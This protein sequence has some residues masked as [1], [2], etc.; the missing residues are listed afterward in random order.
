MLLVFFLP[1]SQWPR[2]SA[3]EITYGLYDWCA[4]DQ[5][6]HPYRWSNQ[7]CSGTARCETGDNWGGRY[8]QPDG[9]CFIP[10]P[11]PARYPYAIDRY[12]ICGGDGA[13]QQGKLT[14]LKTGTV[15]GNWW[16]FRDYDNSLYV[17][18]TLEGTSDA[19]A[20]WEFGTQN[21]APVNVSILPSISYQLPWPPA[22]QSAIPNNGRTGL[23]TC[24][25]YKINLRRVCDPTWT[26]YNPLR[27]DLAGNGFCQAL[28]SDAP[29]LTWDFSTTPFWLKITPFAN[30]Y[31]NLNLMGCGF[32]A[33]TVELN[34]GRPLTFWESPSMCSPWNQPAAPPP[35]NPPPSPETP[36]AP[37]SPPPLPPQPQ[38]PPPPP[39]VAPY[40]TRISVSSQG[41][42]MVGEDCGKLKGI[43]E[44][45]YLSTAL[46][47]NR[48]AGA[49][50]IGG[51]G[52]KSELTYVVP[53]YGNDP[54]PSA[55]LR[56]EMLGLFTA[57]TGELSWGRILEAMQ[58]GCGAGGH[59]NDPTSLISYEVC[60]DAVTAPCTI[61]VLNDPNLPSCSA[62]SPRPPPPAPPPPPVGSP[63]PPRPP[64]PP[65]PSPPPS[66]YVACPLIVVA[67]APGTD[68]DPGSCTAFA[69]KMQAL[70][71]GGSRWTQNFHCTQVA[72][73]Q[74][75]ASGTVLEP[76]DAQLFMAR[77]QADPNGLY[78]VLGISQIPYTCTT[79]I[80][81][82]PY[83]T[84]YDVPAYQWNAETWAPLRT[85]CPSP[86]PAPPPLPPSPPPAPPTPPSAPPSPPP[87]L[88]PPPSPPPVP[89]T[90]VVLTFPPRSM[91]VTDADCVTH[92][93]GWMDFLSL[94]QAD[95]AGVPTCTPVPA[96]NALVLSFQYASDEGGRR[97]P[98]QP[99]P[100]PPPSPPPPPPPPASTGP[101]SPPPPPGLLADSFTLAVVT[102][103]SSFGT[104]ITREIVESQACLGLRAGLSQTLSFFATND[105]SYSIGSCVVQEIL[106]QRFRYRL[107][108]QFA[109]AGASA[110]AAAAIGVLTTQAGVSNL[111]FNTF[112]YCGSAFALTPHELVVQQT[113]QLNP[114]YP[115]VF[116]DPVFGST[117]QRSKQQGPLSAG[118]GGSK[119]E[120]AVQPQL[121]AF[122]WGR[123]A[124]ATPD[125][126]EAASGL[127][128]SPGGGG[129]DEEETSWGLFDP[130]RLAYT[131]P[132]PWGAGTVA[133][134]MA[135]WLASFV[136][137]GFVVVPTIYRTAGINIFELEATDKAVFTFACQLAE[138]VVSLALIRVLTIKSLD[139]APEEDRKQ[140]FNFSLAEPIKGPR[141]WLA[142][143]ALGTVLSPFVVGSVASLMSLFAYEQSVGGRGTVD[144]VAG[145][146]NMD[147]ASYLSLLSV[148]GI[149]APV[150]EETVFRGFLLT[151]LTKFTPTW[152]AIPVSAAFFGA[153]HLS[154]RDFPV[155]FAL[156]CLLGVVYTRSRN[157]LSPIIVH[158]MWNSTVLTLLFYL[159]STGV[160]VE[161]MI[162]TMDQLGT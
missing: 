91:L 124:T 111:A 78:S 130:K 66:P 139:E 6:W 126:E 98:A 42:A 142:W 10:G 160:D 5:P 11:A 112:P 140:F 107:T 156:G 63:Q 4:Q 128:S 50:D 43:L 85:D 7:A 159:A 23:S 89:L 127:G 70:Y 25:T 153:A 116:L 57:V 150:L 79:T 94:T 69:L 114:L 125:Q 18:M 35:P 48:R 119:K 161:E 40:I 157:L 34:M 103:S 30:I 46:F 99:A 110:R 154:P 87:P 71:G 147:L 20:F 68:F 47:Y 14:D 59:F 67:M 155:L 115:E 143:A 26:T 77:W 132:V 162:R 136:A 117:A 16:V 12:G 105:A 28:Y 123:A 8:Q 31:R 33:Q 80:T 158:G 83:C 133:G 149:M 65:Q 108:V 22:Y 36:L 54:T 135:L 52:I 131:W 92:V 45:M 53:W 61:R 60:I 106:P 151:S 82:Y 19:Q 137:V 104:A 62:P 141:G 81:A 13:V 15:W 120:K 39:P 93:A 41:R 152:V 75:T 101:A 49:C 84:Y 96:S 122:K 134:G 64:V 55:A 1:T 29:P 74:M 144:G 109:G 24:F 90:T 32:L 58:L 27:S 3:F 2:A 146:I 21:S 145:M 129:G 118:S 76:D 9:A 44:D 17:T 72:N 56:Q 86:P 88:P 73:G 102:P 37:P 51:V 97:L 138:T 38:P 121:P 113:V 148:T 95:L 100:S